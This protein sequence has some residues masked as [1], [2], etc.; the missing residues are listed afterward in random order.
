MAAIQFSREEM[1]EYQG[2][3]AGLEEGIERGIQRGRIET[4]LELGYSPVRIAG[5]L[6]CPIETVYDVIDSLQKE[7]V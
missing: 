7:T 1:I 4:Y 3:E 6:G 5:K 2:W